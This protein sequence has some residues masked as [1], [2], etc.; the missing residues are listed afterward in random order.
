MGFHPNRSAVDILF[1]IKQMFEK[2]Y[3]YNIDPCNIFVDYA[4][5]FISV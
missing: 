3:E 1:I 4:Q 2:C 5:A